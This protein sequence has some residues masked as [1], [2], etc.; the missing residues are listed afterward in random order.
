[1]IYALIP[2]GGFAVIAGC[3]W[4]FIRRNL[5]RTTHA[6]GIIVGKRFAPSHGSLAANGAP[7][8][9]RVVVVPDSYIFEVNDDGRTGTAVVSKEVFDVYEVGDY[10]AG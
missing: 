2:L 5:K 9:G 4:L 1:M 3:A 6:N 7:G 10:F 8:D